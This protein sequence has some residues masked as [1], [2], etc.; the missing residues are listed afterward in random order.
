VSAIEQS[1]RQTLH[2]L[3]SDHHGW[4]QAW[5]RK[6]LGCTQ[7]AQDLAH[8]TFVRLI[9]A[10][11]AARR[12]ADIRAPR[13]YLTTIARRVMI[14]HFRRRTLERAYLEALALL[15]EAAG[16]SPEQRS[17]IL[18]T[19]CEIDAMLDGLGAKPRQAFLMSQLE[20]LT[21]AEI[22]QRLNVSVSSVNKYMA[23]AV[24]RCLLVMLDYET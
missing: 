7:N 22:A 5:L 17:I 2:A 15:P 9:T 8:D 13:D 12:V 3:Y 10:P 11:D 24:E 21:Y 4:L 18:E 16:I 20:G 23:R 14:D 1:L 6:R 19:L